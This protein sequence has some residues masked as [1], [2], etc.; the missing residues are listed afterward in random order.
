[1][2]IMKEYAVVGNGKNDK[3]APYS[4]CMK[5]VNLTDGKGAYLS[6]KDVIYLD[7]IKPIL[8]I[9]KTKTSIA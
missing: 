7:E 8:T 2:E 5:I 9:V 6:A 3:G 1:M 4:K